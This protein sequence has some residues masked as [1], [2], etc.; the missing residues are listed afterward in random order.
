LFFV[1]LLHCIDTPIL[2]SQPFEAFVVVVHF[3]FNFSEQWFD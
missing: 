2:E 3:S 1:D